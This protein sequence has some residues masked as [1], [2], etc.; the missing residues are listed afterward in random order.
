[1]KTVFGQTGNWDGEDVV[2]LILQQEAAGEF[3]AGK[4]Y[5]FFV[6][7]EISDQMLDELADRL[8]DDNYA[9]KPFLRALFLS[10]DFYSEPSLSTQ[11]KSPVQFL[12]STYRKLGLEKI[13]GTLTFLPPRI[14][15][16]RHWAI[17]R[18]SRAGTAGGPG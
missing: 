4:M 10:Q 2:D 7:D 6:R 15:S 13:P 8:R 1:M 17:R 9:L 16:D 12:V 11:I 18:T 5:R 14:C 3:I